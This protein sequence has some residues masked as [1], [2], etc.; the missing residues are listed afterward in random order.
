MAVSNWGVEQFKEYYYDKYL[1]KTGHAHPRNIK[2]HTGMMR[3][4]I[5]NTKTQRKIGGRGKTQGFR[6]NTAKF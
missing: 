2:K 5:R 4:V 3:N 6:L 1:D